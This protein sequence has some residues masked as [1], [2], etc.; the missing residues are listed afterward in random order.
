MPL[1]KAQNSK[2]VRMDKF[3]IQIFKK[4]K[5]PNWKTIMQLFH[6]LDLDI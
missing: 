4:S 6:F 3:Q 5:L 2:L 1:A